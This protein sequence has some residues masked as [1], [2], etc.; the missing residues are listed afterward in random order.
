MRRAVIFVTLLLLL[1]AVAGVTIAQEGTFL[2]DEPAENISPEATTSEDALP[3]TTT[4]GSTGPDLEI[5]QANDQETSSPEKPELESP[6]EDETSEEEPPETDGANNAP[7]DENKVNGRNEAE[8]KAG[9]EAVDRLQQKVTLCHKGRITIS[10]GTPAQAAHVR[11]GDALGACDAGS[12]ESEDSSGPEKP[13]GPKDS[14]GGPPDNR[15]RSDSAGKPGDA[16]KKSGV[17]PRDLEDVGAAEPDAEG[18]SANGNP[19]GKDKD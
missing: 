13:D 4:P 16:G 3:E 19:G 10:V 6:E 12:T 11:H 15:G 9:D 14:G 7:E 18:T 8:D 5:P 17:A 2:G 1:L